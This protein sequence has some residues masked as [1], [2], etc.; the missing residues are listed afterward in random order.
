MQSQ[1]SEKTQQTPR[2]NLQQTQR[3]EPS[4]ILKMCSSDNL[5]SPSLMCN[6]VGEESFPVK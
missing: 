1:S 5:D 6:I 3:K 2:K 4:E